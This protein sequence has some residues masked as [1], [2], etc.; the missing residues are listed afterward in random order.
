MYNFKDYRCIRFVIKIDDSSRGFTD[1]DLPELG[2]FL[3]PA[4]AM[5]R[6]A[7]PEKGDGFIFS[8][9]DVKYDVL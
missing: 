2:L 8:I 9:N 1:G 4:F 7:F 6:S 5:G 3:V